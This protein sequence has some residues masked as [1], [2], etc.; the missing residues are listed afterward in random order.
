VDFGNKVV[1]RNICNALKIISKV[2]LAVLRVFGLTAKYQVVFLLLHLTLMLTGFTILM[3]KYLEVNLSLLL[4]VVLTGLK[5]FLILARSLVV[6]LSLLLKMML[7]MLDMIMAVKYLEVNSPSITLL[8]R[9]LLLQ[10]Q[11]LHPEMENHF[12]I[13]R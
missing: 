4:K 8:N 7:Q 5:E 12:L 11:P 10:L 6:N 2:K 9:D 13:K 3:V 1:I